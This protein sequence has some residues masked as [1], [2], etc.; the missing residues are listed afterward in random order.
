M[1][2]ENLIH[3]QNQ[4]NSIIVH[5]NIKK[6]NFTYLKK[7]IIENPIYSGLLLF[8]VIGTFYIILASPTVT[9]ECAEQVVNGNKFCRQRTLTGPPPQPGPWSSWKLKACSTSSPP[10]P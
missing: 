5:S 6:M 9:Y 2:L 7:Q 8:L 4:S 10:C 3:D 1:K